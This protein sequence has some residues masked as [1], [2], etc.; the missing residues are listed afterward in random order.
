MTD[1]DRENVVEQSSKPR[2]LIQNM[3]NIHQDS[4]PDVLDRQSLYELMGRYHKLEPESTKDWSSQRVATLDSL[5]DEV[6]RDAYLFQQQEAATAK[7]KL[8]DE[9]RERKLK[10]MSSAMATQNSSR[11]MPV[12]TIDQVFILFLKIFFT[13]LMSP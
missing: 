8:E 13:C 3:K 11:Q 9:K 10:Q 7:Q 12:S 6:N 2:N 1:R 5:F 4:I